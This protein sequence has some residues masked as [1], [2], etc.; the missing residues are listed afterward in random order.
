[1]EKLAFGAE[2]AP[3][4][5]RLRLAR[6]FYHT[7]V[8]NE[9][10]ADG[11]NLILDAGCGR[12]RAPLY[13]K[14]SGRPETETRFVGFDICPVRLEFAKKRGYAQ[15]IQSTISERWPFRD[16]SFDAVICE[17]VLEHL[18]DEQVSFALSEMHRVLKPGGFV[19][20]GTPIFTRFTLLF[21]PLWT[22]L[23]P[24]LRRLKG[25]DTEASH[26]Q[27]YSIA[28]IN[29]ILRHHNFEPE[30]VRGFRLFTLPKQLLED[31]L[32]FYELQQWFGKKVPALCGEV[33]T[34]ARK[35]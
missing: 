10:L 17:Q 8:L 1:M 24:L 12:G 5:Y 6:Y 28:G 33:T 30:S 14:A 21:A 18:T 11:G 3:R 15:L 19:L 35:K 29:K 27:H 31:D 2:P 32:W 22:R 16:E 26:L 25:K 13:W 23:N 4:L 9:K 20:V 7:Q 34:V